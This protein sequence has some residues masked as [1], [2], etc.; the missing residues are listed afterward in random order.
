M[1]IL[2]KTFNGIRKVIAFPF[3]TAGILIVV[4]GIIVLIAGLGISGNT[5]KVINHLESVEDEMN[6]EDNEEDNEKEVEEKEE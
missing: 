3:T 5:D 6:E 4:C 1:N 2:N